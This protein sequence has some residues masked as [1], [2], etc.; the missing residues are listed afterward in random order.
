MPATRP[1]RR[2]ARAPSGRLLGMLGAVFLLAAALAAGPAGSARR[3]AEGYFRRSRAAAGAGAAVAARLAAAGPPLGDEPGPPEPEA[4]AK[5]PRKKKRRKAAAPKGSAA[6]PP[7]LQQRPPT[8]AGPGGAG[9]GGEAA[10]AP[11]GAAQGGRPEGASG[12]SGTLPAS[13]RGRATGAEGGRGTCL[14]APRPWDPFAAAGQGARAGEAAGEGLRDGVGEEVGLAG[15]DEGPRPSSRP[16]GTPHLDAFLKQLNVTSRYAGGESPRRRRRRRRGLQAAG[17]RVKRWGGRRNN[18]NLKASCK[19]V[20]RGVTVEEEVR[21]GERDLVACL[22]SDAGCRGKDRERLAAAARNL[23]GIRMLGG[24]PECIVTTKAGACSRIEEQPE[25]GQWPGHNFSKRPPEDL[26]AKMFGTCAIVGNGPLLKVAAAG[27]AIDGHDAVWRMN[28]ISP[29]TVIGGQRLSAFMGSKTDVRIFNRVRGLEAA[30]LGAPGR[31]RG[32]ASGGAR[33]FLF[34]HYGSI[35][36]LDKIAKKFQGPTTAMLHGRALT[37]LARTYFQLRRDAKRLGFGSRIDFECPE[38]LSSGVHAL[39]LSQLLCEEVNT[40]GLSY[41][42]DML[43]TRPGHLDSKH[44][45][46]KAHSWGFDFLL[47][48]LLHLSGNLHVCTADDP[49]LAKEDLWK[50]LRDDDAAP[51]S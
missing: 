4:P 8:A 18:K 35:G 20:E 23:E 24:A 10:A 37:H 44:T 15:D 12:R 21:E 11:A 17:G 25:S 40:F 33:L 51:G 32:F 1:G 39:L 41:S 9:D 6:Q 30:G 27:A 34:W 22:R 38:N 29:R 2:A 3:A 14:G 45:M 48:R 19:Q 28:L 50:K 13:S 16:A 49:A 36:Y 31:N 43:R 26:R 47:V 46:H 42:P 5:A 7:E